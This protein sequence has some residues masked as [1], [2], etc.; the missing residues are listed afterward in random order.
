[1]QGGLL[2]KKRKT[3]MSQHEARPKRDLKPKPPKWSSPVWYL[4]IML[5]LLWFWQSTVSQFAYKTI[6]YSE[7]KEHL[8]RG[9]V[10]EVVVKDDAAE[11]I[12]R[13]ICQAATQSATPTKTPPGATAAV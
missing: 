7:F 13:S 10:A 1:M 4:P 8:R 5:L 6:P 3:D 11:G 12:S 2:R 9:E